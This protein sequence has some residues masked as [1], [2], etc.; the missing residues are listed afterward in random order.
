[1]LLIGFG[2]YSIYFAG[3]AGFF[4]CFRPGNCPI[5]RILCWVCL[6]TLIGGCSLIFSS[7][8]LLA[9]RQASGSISPQDI[10]AFQVLFELGPGFNFA[11]FGLLFI[12]GFTTCLGLGFSSLPLALSKSSVS[13]SNH[14]ASWSRVESFLWVLLAMLHFILWLWFPPFM[15][16]ILGDII[17]SHLPVFRGVDILSLTANAITDLIVIMI[18]IRVIGED[19]RD[20]LRW[21]FRWP[22]A[23]CVVLAG[24]FP[25][26]IAVLISVGQFLLKMA[27]LTTQHSSATTT[28]SQSGP[29][30]VLPSVGLFLWFLPAFTEEIIFRGLLQ[31][32]FVRRYGV[33]RGI[34]LV[35]IIFAAAH[36]GTDFSTS[37][38]GGLVIKQLCLRLIVSV[39]LSFVFGWLT[40]QSGS[41]FPAA[42]AHGFYNICASF[43]PTF[44]GIGPLI[45]LL[46]TLL[47]YGL[48]RSWPVQKEGKQEPRYV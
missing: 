43:V 14:H 32:I 12:G 36:L 30:F 37:Y 34:F 17:F 3:M 19:A 47:A 18:A 9:T 25:V 28:P 33:S 45:A 11:I 26:G 22:K 6:P 23:E 13:A 39:A 40:L 8:V 20:A 4:I 15:R 42:I 5:R 16:F 27:R 10:T 41:V 35:G 44:A 46:W 29:Y 2:L 21:S 7:V 31:P 38:T 48:F 1:L 24:V